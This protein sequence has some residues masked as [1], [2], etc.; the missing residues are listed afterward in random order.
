MDFIELCEAAQHL[1]VPGK[2]TFH[3]YRPHV[4]PTLRLCMEVESC[5]LIL[6]RPSSYRRQSCRYD[7]QHLLEHFIDTVYV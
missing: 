4:S 6:Q 5:R 3:P 7:L 1:K 2:F